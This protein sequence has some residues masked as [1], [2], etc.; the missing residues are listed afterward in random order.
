MRGTPVSRGARRL[1]GAAS[2]RPDRS[3][4]RDGAPA[5]RAPAAGR[6]RARQGGRGRGGDGPAVVVGQVGERLPGGQGEALVPPVRQPGELPDGTGPDAGERAG[7]GVLQVGRQ[8]RRLGHRSAAPG[9]DEVAL[10]PERPLAGRLVRGDLADRVVHVVVELVEV[11]V[12]VL[13]TVRLPGGE[14]AHHRGGEHRGS[15]VAGLGQRASLEGV[16]DRS[17]GRDHGPPRPLNRSSRSITLLARARMP[18]SKA[19]A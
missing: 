15:R 7:E 4:V 12:P 14:A 1:G 3:R 19:P 11:D 8:L 5:A 17:R 13:V 9:D 2:P 18:R 6:G 10:D 16:L